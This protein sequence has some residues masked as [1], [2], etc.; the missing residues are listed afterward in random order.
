MDRLALLAAVAYAVDRLAALGDLGRLGPAIAAGTWWAVLFIGAVA[1]LKTVGREARLRR[2]L[3][4]DR[5]VEAARRT[6]DDRRALERA[7]L[8]QDPRGVTFPPSTPGAAR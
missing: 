8:A 1:L 4:I 5:R 6:E 3:E 7:R 2:Q